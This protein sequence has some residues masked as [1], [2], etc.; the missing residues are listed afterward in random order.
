ALAWLRTAA[1]D[2]PPRAGRRHCLLHH[3]ASFL[4]PG[5]SGRCAGPAPAVGSQRLRDHDALHLERLVEA[6]EDL[7]HGPP[8]TATA[9]DAGTDGGW[10]AAAGAPRAGEPDQR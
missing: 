8:A 5:R 10:A 7:R 4:R 3:P 9:G 2:E 1:A 6:P